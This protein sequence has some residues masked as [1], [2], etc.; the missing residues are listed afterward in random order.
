MTNLKDKAV[1]IT[2]VLGSLG[3][4]FTD[5]LLA[6]FAVV[7]ATDIDSKTIAN[8]NKLNENNML[9]YMVLDITSEDSIK[10]VFAKVG[11]QYGS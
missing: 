7:I 3:K 6:Q 9:E 11:S 2:G 8:C 1:V 4:V 10:A 5:K